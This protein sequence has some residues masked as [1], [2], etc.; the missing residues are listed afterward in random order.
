MYQSSLCIVY[1]ELCIS[2]HWVCHFVIHNYT[3]SLLANHLGTHQTFNKMDSQPCDCRWSLES[4]SGVC[5]SMYGLTVTLSPPRI[6]HCR[7]IVFMKRRITK[8]KCTLEL[9][10]FAFCWSK[11]GMFVHK[12]RNHTIVCLSVCSPTPAFCWSKVGMFVHKSRNSFN[13]YNNMFI[14][15]TWSK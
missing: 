4:S 8:I 10:I 14:F 11:V 9:H 6:E 7:L 2:P 5:V 1:C 15:H 12:S 13:E 3:L